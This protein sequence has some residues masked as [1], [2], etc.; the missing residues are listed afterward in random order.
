MKQKFIE[1]NIDDLYDKIV[2]TE[3]YLHYLKIKYIESFNKHN[4]SDYKGIDDF[5][6]ELNSL[7]IKKC[8]ESNR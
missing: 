2:K 3:K 8:R 1:D 5:P 6:W 4:K 7:V